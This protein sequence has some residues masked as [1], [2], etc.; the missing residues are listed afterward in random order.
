[1]SDA[2]KLFLKL[3]Q[4]GIHE[5]SEYFPEADLTEI[6]HLAVGHRCVPIVYQGAVSCGIQLS[7]E[8]KTAVIK[9]TMQKERNLHVQTD[10]LRVLDSEGISCV[11]MKG[12]SVA[13]LYPQSFLRQLGDV[14]LLVKESEY[15]KAVS[16]LKNSTV[17]K[18]TEEHPFH[19]KIVIDGI[20]VEIHKYVTE[21]TNDAYGKKIAGIMANAL[22][23][24]N[25][26]EYEGYRFPVLTEKY[27]AMSLLLHTQRHFF[28]NR[29]TMRMLCDWAVFIQ[30]T[31]I[32]TWK[33]EISDM[34][35]IS[36]LDKL[37][38]AMTGMCDLYLGS[39]CAD[40]II[41]KADRELC[42]Y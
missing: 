18:E 23:D 21:Y 28:E 1:M 13:V 38:D 14:D 41:R 9:S 29:L 6:E 35:K 16:L 37:S 12:S 42:F 27:Q 5:T 4:C 33:N 24:I 3:L 31:D 15:E 11:V 10:V 34:I 2:E 22:D 25:Y 32:A 8:W 7:S 26:A 19:C 17:T 39:D 30:Q 40:K 20:A 36:G